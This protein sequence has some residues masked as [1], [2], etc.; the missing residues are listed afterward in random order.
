MSTM[1]PTVAS[2]RRETEMKFE[3]NGERIAHA[4]YT[5]KH[6]RPLAPLFEVL[7]AAL[8]TSKLKFTARS[9]ST[10]PNSVYFEFD[11]GRKV[12]LHGNMSAK[13]IE[14][15]RSKKGSNVHVLDSRAKV[16][17]WVRQGCPA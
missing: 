10:G 17:K 7:A 15:R 5:M 1:Y 8:I 16:R 2:T 6:A 3:W 13:A 12:Y 14:I 11:D 4:L 9:W